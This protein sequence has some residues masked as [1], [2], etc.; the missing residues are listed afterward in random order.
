MLLARRYLVCGLEMTRLSCHIFFFVVIFS[1]AHLACAQVS[2]G[3]GFTPMEGVLPLDAPRQLVKPG[4]VFKDCD[5]CPEMVMIPAGS[6][7]M[8]SPSDPLPDPFSD[9]KVDKK[10]NSDELPQHRVQIK[11]FAI[12]Q[13]E[14]TQEQYYALMG[15]NPSH[16]KGRTLPVEQ[17]SWNDA[18]EFVKKLSAKTGRNYRLPS[19]AEWEYVARAGSTTDFSFG[20]DENLLGSYAWFLKNSDYKSHPV[21]LKK[22]NAFG[23]YDMHGNV[24]EWTQDCWNASYVGAPTDGSAWAKGDCSLRVVRG[25]SWIFNPSNLR[26]AIRFRYSTASGTSSA[27]SGLPGPISS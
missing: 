11:S 21:G 1:A 22:P 2:N 9:E 15:V 17:V 13:Y 25:G 14:I 23:L 3:E 26:S 6:F 20:D 18:Q 7:L 8:G 19:D 27:V 12:G 24:L 10:A 16:F 4:S 5:D